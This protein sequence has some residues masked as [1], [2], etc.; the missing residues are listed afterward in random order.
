MAEKKLTPKQVDDALQILK[1]R[2]MS[3]NEFCKKC[4][5]Q[6]SAQAYWRKHGINGAAAVILHM[7]L[8]DDDWQNILEHNNAKTK[9]L[10]R[11]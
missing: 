5:M 6:S 2:G 9:R 11:K 8:G 7:I 3:G 4:G 10:P 1:D